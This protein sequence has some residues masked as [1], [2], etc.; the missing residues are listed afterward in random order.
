MKKLIINGLFLFLLF[1]YQISKAQ[2]DS[3]ALIKGVVKDVTSK[4]TLPGANIKVAG[5]FNGT[6]TNLNGEY[7]LYVTP[8][9][10][11][12]VVSYIGNDTKTISVEVAAGETKIINVSLESGSTELDDIVV[13]GILG[14]QKKALNQQKSSDNLK[15][16]IS[17]DQMGNFPDQ[18]S[19]ESLQRIQ[20][21]NVLKDEGDGRF[22]MV[23]GLA[24][25]FTNISI[26]G[27]QI[28]S[29]ESESRFMALDAI[30]SNQL[31]SLEVSK[32]ITPDMDG[33][34]IGGSINLIT[35]TAT[36]TD[37][38]ISGSAALEY[39][40]SSQKASGLGSLTISKRSKNDKFG[41]IV[42]GSYSDSKKHSERYKFKAWDDDETPNEL[43]ELKIYDY[44]I[45]RTRIGFNS[46]IDYKIND[47][48]KI[49]F[50]SLY[51]ELREL[52]Q[53]RSIAMASEYNDEDLVVEYEM[54]NVFKY[55]PENQ[56]VYSFNLGGVYENS[57]FIFDYEAAISQAFQV[58]DAKNE[59]VFENAG[60]VSWTFDN[61]NRLSPQI[62]GFTFD[63][64]S[65]ADFNDASMYEF[66]SYEIAKTL[67]EDKNVTAKFNMAIPIKLSKYFGEIKFGGK[68]RMKDK[69]FE[70]QDFEEYEYAGAEDMLL[71]NFDDGLILE[72]FMD[73]ELNQDIGP[74]TD[75]DKWDSFYNSNSGDFDNDPAKSEE[76][77][78]LASYNASEDVYA[79]YLQGKIQMNKMMILAGLRYE[80]TI[81]EYSS[82]V[83]DED[84]EAPTKVKGEND[85]SYLL[86][87]L[88]LKYS[89]NDNNI[90]RSSIT[91]S[92]SRPNFQDLVQGATFNDEEAEISNPNLVPVEAINLDLF[93]EHYLGSIGLLSG[94]LFYKKLDNF[95]YQQTNNG[96]FAGYQDI[97]ITQSINGDE[98]TLF[99]F[100]I[101]YQQDLTFL[102]GFLKGF[103]VY[104][105]YTYTKSNAT[106]ENF[107][108]DQDLTDIRLPGQA[109]NIGNAALAYAHKGFKA[110]FSVNYVDSYIKEFDGGDLVILD[111]RTQLDF[112]MSQAFAKNKWTAYVELINLT[113]ANQVELFNTSSTPKE[114]QHYG[115]WGRM[116][117][118]FNF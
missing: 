8:G 66:K 48:N 21:V 7:S 98:A 49:Y 84:I 10:F 18:N 46:T 22:V 42:S 53:R 109:E 101:G 67:A 19:A 13:T 64:D 86:P 113:D 103:I 36:G 58:T 56:G 15:S 83:W 54:E 63:G 1:S 44:E 92:Y 17:S 51:S 2:S 68:L 115:F 87:M 96:D 52:E 28:P 3:K 6:A 97:E 107:T 104:V 100:E 75:K 12:I 4:T 38:S 111:N 90:I 70:I 30:P 59:M 105:N 16:V 23:R 106:V 102:P 108:Q 77:K 118:R 35:P 61:S 9:K 116:G 62:T 99:G 60:D 81:F 80:N 72:G 50:R 78:T 95:I 55:R 47:K 82:G 39:N 32:S 91:K 88:H 29:P 41:F 110:R 40:N 85:Y 26:N 45:D 65:N 71:N 79:G 43:D 20:G 76:E 74:Y 31:A 11:E 93:S 69:S 112:S 25:S 27:E 5:T 37:L 117:L 89:I 94:G 34:A 14:G 114:R 73:G 24:P 33:D 57:K